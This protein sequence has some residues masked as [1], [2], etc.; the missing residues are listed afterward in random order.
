M[1][2]KHFVY[3]N[4]QKYLYSFFLVSCII[5]AQSYIA[6]DCIQIA[7]DGKKTVLSAGIDVNTAKK[8][9]TSS[10]SGFLPSL[11]FS[12]NIAQNKFPNRRSVDFNFESLTFDT[13]ALVQLIITLQVCL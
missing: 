11:Q 2:K 13:T 10:Y 12:T 9:L 1:T 6:N 5:K 7:L 3:I 8:G 4:E